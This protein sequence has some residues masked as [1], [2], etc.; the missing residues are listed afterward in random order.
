MKSAEEVAD[1]IRLEIHR[2]R[3]DPEISKMIAKALTDYA[4]ESNEGMS[5]GYTPAAV[6]RLVDKARDE[7]WRKAAGRGAL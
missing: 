7:A 3:G 5:T 6:K 2:L 4:E 1:W